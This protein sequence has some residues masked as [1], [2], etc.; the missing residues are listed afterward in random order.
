LDGELALMAESTQ[1]SPEP[2]L[3]DFTIDGK[4]YKAARGANL[5][6]VMLA[7][8]ID[9]SYFCYHPGL[10]VVAVCR[11]C[12]VEVKGSPKLVP[13]CQT[14]VT[15]NMAVTANSERVLLARRQMLEFTLLN[16][17][18]DCP[19]CDKA[20][21]CSLQKAYQ[22]WDARESRLDHG[23]VHKPKRV[24]IGPR[25]I[26]DDERCILCT[27]CVR[28]CAEVAGSPQLVIAKRGNRSVLT[29]APGTRL[30][31][32][33]SLNTV[34]I[35]PVGALTDRDFRFQIRVW[36]L[37]ST[38]SICNG[39]STGCKCEVHHHRDK[40]YRQVP[41]RF[42]DINLNWMC[43]Y[44][45][46]TYK[47]QGADRLTQPLI[48]GNPTSWDESAAR[49][50]GTIGPLLAGHRQSVGVVLGADATNED[51]YVAARIAFDFLGLEQVYLAAEPDGD[52]GDSVLRSSDPNPNKAGA[53]AC[54]RGK[55]R[56]SAE[57]S[58]DLEAG[59][60]RALYVVGD[61][62][63]LSPE[64]L[65]RSSSLELLAVQATHASTLT[66]RAHVV[67]PACAWQE[68]DGTIT[69]RKGEVQRLRAAVHPPGAARPHWEHLVK[70]ARRMGM[71]LELGGPRAVFEAMQRE[72]VF[73]GQAG[74][75]R[76]LQT[77]QLRFAGSRG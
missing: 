21:E 59:K 39:C 35:C 48:D 24:E 25:V 74:W 27:R 3:V 49:I 40:I 33:Y 56:S 70:L 14:P 32:P 8:G 47:A 17:P 71:T 19:I 58:A 37:S 61:V 4:P 28:F 23:K 7:S 60:L 15:P 77:T 57:L 51:N 11:Q 41:R 44:G 1:R 18:V 69:N 6:D 50:A 9:I 10:T 53:I 29:V 30:D 63:A 12:L 67:L 55:V 5:L 20:G 76:D 36:L 26:L 54:A 43:D 66:R 34:D 16:H 22:E 42:R 2:E 72:V 68:V 65:G 38:P 13:A 75:G 62:L 45:R 52:Q 64:A 31:T 73:F 46:Y